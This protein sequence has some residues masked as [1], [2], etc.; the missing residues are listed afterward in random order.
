MTCL[1]P[2]CEKELEMNVYLLGLPWALSETWHTKHPSPA[3]SKYA[4]WIHLYYYYLKMILQGAHFDLS[5]TKEAHIW[6][7]TSSSQGLP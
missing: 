7:N 1:N 4:L 2:I 5:F 6:N 3:H